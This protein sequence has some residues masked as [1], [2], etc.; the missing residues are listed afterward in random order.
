MSSHVDLPR[1]KRPVLGT[2]VVFLF[3]GGFLLTLWFQHFRKKRSLQQNSLKTYEPVTGYLSVAISALCVRGQQAILLSSW[4]VPIVNPLMTHFCS[5]NVWSNQLMCLCGATAVLFACL[6][7][8]ISFWCCHFSLPWTSTFWKTRSCSD[9]HN[10][11]DQRASKQMIGV[12]RFCLW[13]FKKANCRMLSGL[14]ELQTRGS[15][16]CRLR[17]Q[18]P[19]ALD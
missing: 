6:Q 11:W 12:W 13:C 7:R 10:E 3:F 4:I 15:V 5:H 2:W 17:C 18:L 14:L 16:V 9:K 8:L 19:V 1:G